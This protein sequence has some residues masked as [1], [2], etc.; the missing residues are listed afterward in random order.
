MHGVND[1]NQTGFRSYTYC[2]HIIPRNAACIY[3][4]MQVAFVHYAI[5]LYYN[6]IIASVTLII[7]NIW[8]PA[9][10]YE[11]ESV[12]LLFCTIKYNVIVALFCCSE[13]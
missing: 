5:G 9:A 10:R 1:G 4:H 12:I 2:C 11:V 7:I 3:S 13:L 8:S 6:T